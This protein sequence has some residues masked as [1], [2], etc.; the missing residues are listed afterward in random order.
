MANL[1]KYDPRLEALVME[2]TTSWDPE[3]GE[4]SDEDRAWL[5]DA[6]HSEPD[7]AARI[8][9]ERSHTGFT[10]GITVTV[11]D[12]QRIYNERSAG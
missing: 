3:V 6:V 4:L 5:S 8:E 7:K 9:Y 2:T 1:K 11:A 12:I 10:R